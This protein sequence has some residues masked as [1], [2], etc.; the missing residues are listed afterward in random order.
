[1]PYLPWF[2]PNLAINRFNQPDQLAGMAAESSAAKKDTVVKMGQAV[3]AAWP[4]NSTEPQKTSA[5]KWVDA[6]RQQ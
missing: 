4:S 6:E 5:G 2:G 3:F 1:V